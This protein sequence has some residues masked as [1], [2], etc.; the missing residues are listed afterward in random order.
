MYWSIVEGGVRYGPSVRPIWSCPER[1]ELTPG[2]IDTCY[3]EMQDSRIQE[4]GSGRA[5]QE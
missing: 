3:S 5:A 2:F 4:A 1:L